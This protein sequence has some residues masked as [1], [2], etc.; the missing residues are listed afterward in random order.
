MTSSSVS[1]SMAPTADYAPLIRSEAYINGRWTVQADGKSFAVTNP[2]TGLVITHV[3]DMGRNETVA[4]VEAAA[5]AFP[6]WR[7]LLAGERARILRQWQTLIVAHADALAALMTAEQGK[8]LTEAR[9]EILSGAAAVEWAAE[10]AKRVY[11]DTIPTHKAD[12]RVIVTREPVGVVGAITP[13]NFPHSMITRKVAPA[14]AAG[15]TIVLKPAEDTP[16]SALALA[17]LAQE[18][19]IPAGVFNV[20]TGSLQSAPVIGEVLTTHPLVKKISFTGSTEVGKILMR[21]SAS[22]VKK[23]SLELGGN[24][25]LIVFNSAPMEKAV[26]GAVASKFR[27]AGQTCICANRIYVQD[28]IYDDFVRL[29]I[30]K[31][32]ALK[33]GPGDQPGVQIGP[34][35]NADGV[36]KVVQHIEDAKAKG[37]KVLH[38]GHHE[39]GSLFFPPTVLGDMTPAMRVHHEETFGPVAGLFRF[40][41]EAD[42]I[43]LANDTAYGLASY[44]YT[45]DLGQAFRVAEALEYGMV[46]INEPLLAAASVPFGGIKESGIGREGS[47]Y[48]I[49]DFVNMKYMLVG[50]L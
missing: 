22:T 23:L 21:Q 34:M 47:K 28:G 43:R 13:W 10:E 39:D 17:E 24:A 46:G 16:L 9:A 45:S 29:F 19:G 41:D 27:N 20:V 42:V 44:F 12:A 37:A 30:E 38:G 14:L 32:K 35:I 8:P 18:A 48:G 5:A 31:V 2:A 49:E 50:G 26:D 1:S 7:K 25:P 4:A 3:P 36:A 11:G 40:S 15:C 33:I 6:A